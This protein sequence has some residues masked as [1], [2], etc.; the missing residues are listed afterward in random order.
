MC[1]FGHVQEKQAS[2]QAL[3]I[4]SLRLLL[5]FTWVLDSKQESMVKSWRAKAIKASSG[6]GVAEAPSGGSSGSGGPGAPAAKKV[7]KK[8]KT[9]AS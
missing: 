6:S 3:D 1:Q 4:P 9:K 8:T 2:N 5:V 7:A